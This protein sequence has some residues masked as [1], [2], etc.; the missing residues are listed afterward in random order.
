[1]GEVEFNHH[2][3]TT[4]LE[5]VSLQGFRVALDFH[6]NEIIFKAVKEC[7][8]QFYIWNPS[9][10]EGAIK[11]LRELKQYDE[12]CFKAGLIGE[13]QKTPVEVVC[14]QVEWNNLTEA[15]FGKSFPWI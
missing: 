8:L 13:C 3:S 2:D 15:F 11:A 12:E 5:N 6:I 4:H 1:M 7:G 10:I 9:G 14:S